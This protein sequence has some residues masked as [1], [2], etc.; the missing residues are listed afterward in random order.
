MTIVV[1]RNGR[2]GSWIQ[3]HGGG[4]YRNGA[5]CI[6]L[7]RG[8]MLVAGVM[9]D[10]FNGASIYTHIAVSG[11]LTR[12]YLHVIFDYPFRQLRAKVL[13][14]LVAGS[15]ARARRFVQHLGFSLTATIPE[16]YPDGSLLIY[17][18]RRDQCR[19]LRKE[20]EQAEST[21]AA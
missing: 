7:E 9:Y 16:G 14:G 17:T 20:H 13:I 19:W 18:M 4:Y 2:V 11:T 3:S 12:E 8:G 1:H 15:N 5:Q 6:G 21:A 10:Y